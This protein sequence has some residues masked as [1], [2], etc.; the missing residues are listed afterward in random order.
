M[1]CSGG[2]T[3]EGAR[4]GNRTACGKCFAFVMCCRT[5]G[6]SPTDGVTSW[7]ARVRPFRWLI[8]KTP[9]PFQHHAWG[10]MVRPKGVNLET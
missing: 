9:S 4:T 5:P 1:A 6:P 3:A 2:F 7:R 8:D 10:R